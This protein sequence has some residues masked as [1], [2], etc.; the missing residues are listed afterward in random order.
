MSL[1][2][3]SDK[4]L[5]KL[6]MLYKSILEENFDCNDE[7]AM[8]IYRMVMSQIL[9]ACQPL[10]H[11]S[12][13]KLHSVYSH[14]TLLEVNAEGSVDLVVPYLGA[15]FTGVGNT[16]IAVRPIHTSIRDFLLDAR[17]SGEYAINLSEGHSI[18][19]IA[20]IQLMTENLHFNMCNLPSSYLHNS[21]VKD[22]ADRILQGLSQELSYACCFWD[23]HLLHIEPSQNMLNIV[24]RF[25]YYFSLYWMEALS[26]L[27]E[28]HAI[29]RILNNV[30]EWVQKKMVCRFSNALYCLE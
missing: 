8:K 28:V 26:I 4:G 14:Y 21:E 12:L 3:S 6:D 11:S 19:G 20:T 9:V 1:A 22:L 17:R 23:I 10:S 15:L 7:E 16:N 25:L 24:K 2:S 30:R 13:N 29:A 27:G 18:M 5:Q